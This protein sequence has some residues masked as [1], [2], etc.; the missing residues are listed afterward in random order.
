MSNQHRSRRLALQGLCC[1]DAQGTNSWALVEDFIRDSRE[2][3]M[4][5]DRA[6]QVLAEAFDD[7]SE[8]D[9]ILKRH[10]RRWDIPRLAL[11]DRN[12]LRLGVHELR[13]GKAPFKVVIS[14]SLR[15]AREF[16]SAESPRFVNGILDAVAREIAHPTS[17]T[18]TTAAE[19]GKTET[20]ETAESEP[21]TADTT[22]TAEHSDAPPPEASDTDSDSD[23]PAG[24]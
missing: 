8:C 18:E 10:A 2:P 19:T 1:I 11:V 23:V 6:L 16:S 22:D 3:S 21:P 17:D 15:L 7:R 14:E 13:E 9:E 4:V 24:E 12:I 5:L 20:S